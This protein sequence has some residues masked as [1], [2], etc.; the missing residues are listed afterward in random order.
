MKKA[1]KLIRMILGIALFMAGIVFCIAAFL[2]HATA[3][4]AAAV[5]FCAVAVIA[6]QKEKNK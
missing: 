3:Y 6:V 1:N 5:C 4:S 2:G